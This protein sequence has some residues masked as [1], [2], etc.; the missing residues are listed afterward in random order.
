MRVL[1]L[2]PQLPYPPNKGTAI[3]NFN[4]IKNL[5]ARHELWLISF[6]DEQ[7]ANGE[8]EESLKVL[9]SLCYRV[10]TVPTPRRSQWRR[11]ASALLSPVPDLALR[12]SSQEFERK[13]VE[14]LSA[15]RFDVV[16]IEGLEMTRLWSNGWTRARVKGTPR[17]VLDEHNAEYVLQR[18]AFEIDL[19]QPQRWA[20]AVY[21]LLQWRKLRR[22]EAQMCRR[23]DAVVAVSERDRAQLAEL[24]GCA[25]IEVVANG[26]DVGYFDDLS[27]AEAALGEA[28]FVFTGTMDFRP[29]VDGVIWF[30]NSIWP[31]ILQAEPAARFYIVGRNPKPEVM[32]LEREPSVIVT[33]AVRDIRP[34]FKA[35]VLSVVP[36]RM[37]GGSRLKILEAMAAGTPVLSTTLGAEGI[38]ITPGVNIAIADDP[39]G[40]A[41]EAVAL[42]RQPDR[43]LSLAAKARALVKARY[44]WPAVVP[45][46]DALYQRLGQTAIHEATPTDTK[47]TKMARGVCGE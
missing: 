45:A 15:E 35:A 1:F 44:D 9:Q 8:V 31:R 47:G 30:T 24:S 11:L 27:F 6:L 37:G 36:V 29:N 25:H 28:S 17:L 39:E 7:S 42:L 33:G 38:D 23:M 46:M 14:I 2:T 40:F 12:L 20:A 26:V 16:Q 19:G 18:R 22:Y 3:R 5:A 32:A 43:R 34:F 41:A 13:L 4:I 10:E 21:S